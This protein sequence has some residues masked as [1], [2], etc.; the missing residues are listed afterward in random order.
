MLVEEQTLLS[1]ANPSEAGGCNPALQA[2]RI[3]EL[4]PKVHPGQARGYLPPFREVRQRLRQGWY[5]SWSIA[6]GFALMLAE[7]KFE[8][9]SS[10][11]EA[12]TAE[13][14]DVNR[15]IRR[16]EVCGGYATGAL[17]CGAGAATRQGGLGGGTAD[18]R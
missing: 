5:V 18:C 9:Y 4:T 8:D 13:F 16:V 14:G 7:D 2:D 3:V 15:R 12:N 11:C 17:S 1:A 10:H 6:S